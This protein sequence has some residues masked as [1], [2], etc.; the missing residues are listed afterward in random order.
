[1]VPI[2]SAMSAGPLLVGGEH[3]A[4][5]DAQELQAHLAAI[6]ESSDDA[7]LSKSLSGKILSWNSAAE[8]LYGYR[9]SEAVGRS[10]HMIVPEELTSEVNSLLA[11]VATGE[12]VDHH[13]TQRVRKDGSRVAVS[14]TISPIRAA[15]GSISAASVIARDI[16]E[17]QQMQRRLTQLANEDQLTGIANRRSFIREIERHVEHC[18]RYGWR[19]AVVV[20]DVDHFKSVNDTLGHG[21]GDQL[22]KQTAARL[23]RRL[24]SA[25][26]LARMGGD[27]FAVLLPE[28]GPRDTPAVAEAIVRELARQQ[29]TIADRTWT[30]I[31]DAVSSDELMIRAD[32]AAYDAKERGGNRSAGYSIERDRRISETAAPLFL[33]EA[34][35]ATE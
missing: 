1:V 11:R 4:A 19:G 18:G 6:V 7:I 5:L 34:S 21:A 8:R 12:R 35:G 25:D 14:L 33:A 26:V 20:I 23:R 28:A 10:I 15:N 22:L 30:V 3:P 17:R 31:D 32:L 13:D 24:R 16:T 9:P 29:I 2:L 27:E